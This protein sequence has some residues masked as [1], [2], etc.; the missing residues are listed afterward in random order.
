MRYLVAALPE[1]ERRVIERRFG[2]GDA[3]IWT[4]QQLA[5]ELAVTPQA[6]RRIEIRALKRLQGAMLVFV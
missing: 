6:V 2:L 4:L 3:E 1:R 5:N